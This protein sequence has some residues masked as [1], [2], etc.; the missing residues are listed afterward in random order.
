MLAGDDDRSADEKGS[1]EDDYAN[2]FAAAHVKRL[3]V[4]N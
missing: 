1:D 3:T 4:E 2:V